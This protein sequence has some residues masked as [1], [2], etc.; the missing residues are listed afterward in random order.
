M[1]RNG[2]E[3]V[4][5]RRRVRCAGSQDERCHVEA[6]NGVHNRVADL[7][8]AFP[9]TPIVLDH[10]GG[11][12]GY[13]SYAGR[14]DEA[15]SLY[16]KVLEMEPGF[17]YT[18]LE[19]GNACAAIGDAYTLR[20][21]ELFWRPQRAA[22][23]QGATLLADA[24]YVDAQGSRT[25]A[26]GRLLAEAGA[27]PLAEI[28]VL[29]EAT[30][31]GYAARSDAHDLALDIAEGRAGQ[32]GLARA[33]EAFIAHVLG[34]PVRIQPVPVI[35]DA[36]WTWHVGL[37][38]EATAIA[39]D[40]WQGRSVAQARLARILWLARLE[41]ADPARVLARA[42]GRPVYLALAMDAAQQV[43]MKPQ[44]LLAGLPLEEGP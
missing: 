1:L 18:E 21:A 38:A 41:F 8:A 25:G 37:D 33:L 14:H 26:L 35:E 39:N 28:T 23:T 12:L 10:I 4:Q 9:E 24:E 36:H 30:A 19:M 42:R 3:V 15:M 5:R 20:A 43:R 11:P 32:H 16:R 40:L 17:H 22:L 6:S 44:N 2:A 13:A 34:T 27:S 29:G 7:A 31:P